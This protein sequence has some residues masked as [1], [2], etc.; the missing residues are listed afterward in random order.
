MIPKFA[1]LILFSFA[2]AQG[3][4]PFGPPEVKGYQ[5]WRRVTDTPRLMAPSVAALCAPITS[6][7][8][9]KKIGGPH[10]EAYFHVYV[11]TTGEKQFFSTKQASYPVG[12]MIVKEKFTRAQNAPVDLLTIM[13]KRPKGFS[14]RNGDWEYVVSN[15]KGVRK[16]F[17]L[18]SCQSCHASK[19]AQDFVFRD[20]ATESPSASAAVKPSQP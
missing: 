12:T 7:E 13:I 18:E 15:A 20:Y 1:I 2:L 19:K 11:N 6:K 17:E 5:T 3:A 9:A 4:K 10:A 8:L 14:P 16:N